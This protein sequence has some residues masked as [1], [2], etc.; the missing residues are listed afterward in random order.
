MLTQSQLVE[1]PVLQL[2]TLKLREAELVAKS[3]T[4]GRTRVSIQFSDREVNTA[5]GPERGDVGPQFWHLGPYMGSLTAWNI[6]L[7]D[8]HTSPSDLC[9]ETVT[10]SGKIS[11]SK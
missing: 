6:L 11:L 9:P 10:F 8:T 3:H 1:S 7:L 4:T 2:K 5:L